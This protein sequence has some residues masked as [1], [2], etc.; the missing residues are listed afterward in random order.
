MDGI[1]GSQFDRFFS[2]FLI[3]TAT[4]HAY[5]RL[6]AAFRGVVYMPVVAATRLKSDIYDRH[7]SC[8]HGRNIALSD[9]ILGIGI[10]RLANRK[11]DGLCI[12]FERTDCGTIGIFSPNLFC[13]TKSCPC[14]GPARIKSGV[15][16]DFGHFGFGYS[17]FL[18]RFEVIL[19]RRVGQSLR[20]EGDHRYD[21]AVAER[22]EVIATPHLPE[23]D[24]VIEVREL[25]CELAE[26]V[27]S[28]CLLDFDL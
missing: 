7:A 6:P 20:H 13:H 17:V 25:G 3:I 10:I 24:V 2:P 9:E 21:G 16:K 15:G 8:H 28:G 1:A 22:K 23:K 18:C 26:R 5:E 14:L 12:F 4:S 27:T 11:N 19:E